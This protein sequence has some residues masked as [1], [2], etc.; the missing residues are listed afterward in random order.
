MTRIIMITML[1]VMSVF[2]DTHPVLREQLKCI[3][4]SS[5][6]EKHIEP[7]YVYDANRV[8]LYFGAS[9]CGACRDF[10]QTKLLSNYD[11]LGAVVLYVSIDDNKNTTYKY[12]RKS[13]MPWNV[14]MPNTGCV[15]KMKR[16]YKV[17]NTIPEM[18]VLDSMDNVITKGDAW[19]SFDNLLKYIDRTKTNTKATESIRDQMRK[20]GIPD[21]LIN[22]LVTR[23]K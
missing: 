10:Y 13:K 12:M 2:A 16:L 7:N 20:A 1:L 4:N 14:V 15:D 11:S 8:I 5:G 6:D 23:S 19:R 18:A 9:W 3:A 21:S 17:G 22:E